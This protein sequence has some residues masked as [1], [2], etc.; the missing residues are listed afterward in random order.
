MSK[1]HQLR[2]SSGDTVS[3]MTPNGWVFVKFAFDPIIGTRVIL[4]PR[5]SA[6][7]EEF[8]PIIEESAKGLRCLGS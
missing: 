7:V 5:G 1:D 8:Q 6:V 3:I 2:I 4:Q